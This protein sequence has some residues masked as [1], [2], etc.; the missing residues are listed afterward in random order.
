MQIGR[1]EIQTPVVA[2]P[3]A[4]V[5]NAAFRLLAREAGAGLVCSEMLSAKGLVYN[6]ERN[7]PLVK[8]Y[9]E[10][11]PISMQIF[12]ADPSFM[13]RAARHL[14]DLGA[15]IIDI[16]MGC[17]VAKVVKSG[18]GCALMRE[19]QRAGEIIA[20]VV[21]AVSLPVTVKI[22][23]GWKAEE[24]NAVEV[25][26]LARERGVSAVTVHG[27]TREQ[28]YGGKADW[29]VIRQVA[30]AVDIPVIGSGDIF[31]PRD[32]LA[33]FRETG[34]SAVMV[35]RGALGNPWIFQQIRALL[36]EGK[37]LPPPPGEERAAVA[38]RH[39]E[40]LVDLKGEKT[41]V[42]EMRKHAAWYVKGAP[43]AASARQELLRASTREEMRELL[44][45]FLGS[46]HSGA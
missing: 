21:Q 17:P 37:E 1:V 38:L 3:M 27:R 30:E 35:G 40:L 24:A 9:P 36:E 22:R 39:L 10:E 26:R 12:G 29:G 16:N 14:Q 15:D 6:P 5:S 41:G 33:M 18:E 11:R 19:P 7:R 8:F 44:L 20:A 43:G 34:C 45:R 4:G 28:F 25:A 2:A 42:R 32:A 31:H 46:G 13:V 23:K